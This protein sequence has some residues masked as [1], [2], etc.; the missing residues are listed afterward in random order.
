ML[1]EDIE[2]NS[3]RLP[4]SCPLHYAPPYQCAR[5]SGPI[6]GSAGSVLGGVWAVVPLL[7]LQA[8]VVLC[9]GCSSRL[10]TEQTGEHSCGSWEELWLSSFPLLEWDRPGAERGYCVPCQVPPLCW[11]STK[12]VVLKSRLCL[13]VVNCWELRLATLISLFWVF[14]SWFVWLC[15]VL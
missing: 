3:L 10:V 12:A 15:L 1:P 2:N 7:A 4:P 14:K 13:T 5:K 11:S 9:C 6:G 8:A